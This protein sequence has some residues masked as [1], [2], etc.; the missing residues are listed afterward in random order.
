MVNAHPRIAI[1]PETHWIPELLDDQSGITREGLVTP[2]LIPRLLKHRRFIKLRI[3]REDLETLMGINQLVPYSSFVT[4]IFDLYGKAQGKALVGDKTPRYVRRMHTLHALWPKARFLHLIRDGR[5][6]C[7]SMLNWPRAREGDPGSF[8]A[9]RDD[10]VTTIAFW[11]ELNV[12]LGRGAGKSLGPEL[13]YE[14]RYESLVSHPAEECAALCA[15]LGLPYDDAMLR[16]HVGRT[17][18]KHARDTKHAWLPVTPALRD[19]TSQMC[20]NDVERV[21]A[22]VGGLLAELG[23]PRGVPHPRPEA[24]ECASRI[25]D[26]LDRD[27]R[28]I[29]LSREDSVAAIHKAAG[30]A[31]ETA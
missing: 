22:A 25:G 10:P 14:L 7:L 27:P 9:W 26:S 13:Y 18:T 21:E 30:Y 8:A 20:P 4:G 24:L 11:W 16:F 1:T 15:F 2:E 29:D 5:D 6:V 3:G 28:W 19:W 17:K 31:I 23:Y 12:Q